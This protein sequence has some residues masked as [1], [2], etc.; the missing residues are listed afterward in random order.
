MTASTL[1]RIL[2]SSTILFITGLSAC[3]NPSGGG[4]VFGPTASPTPTSTPNPTPTATPLPP[5]VS[6]NGEVISQAEFDAELARYQQAQA[7][8]GKTVSPD[9]AK[10]AVMTDVVD[11]LLLAQGSSIYGFVV[12]DAILQSRIDNLVFQVGGS[13]ALAAWELAHGYKDADFRSALRRQ[14]AAAW[15]ICIPVRLSMIWL[16]GMT[17]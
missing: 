4:L 16:P 13:D 10:Q 7:S 8:L 2:V 17:R 11:N 3:G 14:I 12:N 15:V 5:A 1:R 9:A 6:V